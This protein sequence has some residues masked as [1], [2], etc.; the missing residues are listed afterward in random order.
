LRALLKIA[1]K[2][3]PTLQ[4]MLIDLLA[5]NPTFLV[6][7]KPEAPPELGMEAEA[8]DPDSV[9]DMR[10]AEKALRRPI[11]LPPKARFSPGPHIHVQFDGGAQDGHGTGGFVIL[12]QDQKEVLRAGRYYGPGR[13]NNEAEAFAMRD[14]MHCLA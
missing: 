3:N 11:F 2:A 6:Q 10:T 9:E 4:A 5:Y 13:T 8:R 7:E 14:A 12:D 1:N